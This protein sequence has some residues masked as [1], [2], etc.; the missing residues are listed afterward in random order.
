MI[1]NYPVVAREM[2]KANAP[3]MAWDDLIETMSYDESMSNAEYGKMY[4]KVM[5]IYKGM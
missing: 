5:Q 1:I 4:D 2:A 3:D